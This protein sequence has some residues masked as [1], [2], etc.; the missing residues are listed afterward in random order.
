MIEGW[1]RWQTESDLKYNKTVFTLINNING[2]Y[3]YTTDEYQVAISDPNYRYIDDEASG[4][5]YNGAVGFDNVLNPSSLLNYC[6]KYGMSNI[7]IA[8]SQSAVFDF[9]YTVDDLD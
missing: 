5:G 6:E 2:Y 4:S 7:P 8:L 3:D 1:D 9:G